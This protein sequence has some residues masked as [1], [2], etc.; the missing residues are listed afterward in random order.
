MTGINLKEEFPLPADLAYLN[1]AGVAPWPRRTAAAVQ[2]FAEEN[3][4]HGPVGYEAW[5]ETEAFL[6]TQLRTLL[7]APSSDDIALVKNTSEALSFV[8]HGL[9]WQSGDNVV[10]PSQEFPSNRVVWE[11]LAPQGVEV[12]E[13]NLSAGESPEAAL[14]AAVDGRTRLMS[15]SSVQYGTGLRLDLAALGAYCHDY[16]ILFC[17][18]AIQSLGALM[19]DVQHIQADFVMADGHKW[20]LAPEGLGVFYCRAERRDGLQLKQFGWHMVEHHTDFTR[21]DWEPAKGARRFECG[22]PNMVGIHG[23]HASLSLIAEVGLDA[24]QRNVL[25][26]SKYLIDYLGSRPDIEV[27]T[28]AP[29]GRRAGI[30]TFRPLGLDAALLHGRLRERGV[31]GALRN[32]GVRLSPHFY[33]TPQ[34]LD[35]ALE[36]LASILDGD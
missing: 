5:L 27:M 7:N 30:V 9:D 31:V 25:N 28:P 14:T 23:L 3:A 22:S 32:G 11:S 6:R 29:E 35:M 18:D 10:I 15:V 24:I 1:H 33:N 4:T 8:A 16:R 21:R 20:L 17:V 12:R 2:R 34:T 36:A 13:V 19:M 26:N